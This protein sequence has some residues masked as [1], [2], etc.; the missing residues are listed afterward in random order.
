LA[1]PV[2]AVL[3]LCAIAAL[4]MTCEGAMAEWSGV[5]LSEV[6]RAP[7]ALAALGF[8]AFSAA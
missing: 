5:F 1:L 3:P 6:A 7:Q 8:A 4:F 2:P